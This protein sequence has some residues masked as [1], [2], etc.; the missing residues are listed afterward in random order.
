RDNLSN[1]GMNH[2]NSRLS[3]TIKYS[4]NA[5][6]IIQSIFVAASV[7]EDKDIS[8]GLSVGGS[9]IF[10]VL[11]NGT[12]VPLRHER[13][14]LLWQD[15]ALGY[16]MSAGATVSFTYSGPIVSLTQIIESETQSTTSGSGDHVTTNTSTSADHT[17]SSTS[18]NTLSPPLL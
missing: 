11:S 3:L 5:S 1:T 13:D 7:T 9:I 14:I 15:A 12:L 17:E 4:G 16:N 10:S 2:S 6:A 8:E 18:S